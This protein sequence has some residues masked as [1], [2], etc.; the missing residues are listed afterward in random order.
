MS[1]S[2]FFFFENR[3]VYEIMWNNIVV[4][5][6]PQMSLWRMRIACSMPKDTNTLSKYVILI[7]FIDGY[8][9]CTNASQCYVTRALPFLL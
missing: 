6:R 7:P 2:F 1:N 8:S 9:G 4:P 3:A 5:S